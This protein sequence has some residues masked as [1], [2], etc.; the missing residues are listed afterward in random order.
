VGVKPRVSELVFLS[1]PCTV[2]DKPTP[3]LA[4]GCWVI[5]SGDGDGK[6][7]RAQATG[8]QRVTV[9]GKTDS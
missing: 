6:G 5:V 8:K 9:T 3:V 7:T 2:V 4:A 1:L